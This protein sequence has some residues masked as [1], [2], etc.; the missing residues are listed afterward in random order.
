M[1]AK[2]GY[3][4]ITSDAEANVAFRNS[5]GNLQSGTVY[6]DPLGLKSLGSVKA[7]ESSNIVLNNHPALKSMVDK[8]NY[9][10][11]N[12]KALTTE[13]G[14]A[15][16]AGYALVPVYVDPRIIDRSIKRLP[17][18]TLMPRVA[19]NGMYAA[20]NYISSKGGAFTAA[21]DAS[22]SETNTAYDRSATAIKFLYSVGRTTGPSIAATPSYSLEGVA[23]GNEGIGPASYTE[24]TA[25][26]AN[27]LEIL[28]KTRELKELEENLL[29]NGNS[30]TSGVSGNPDGTEFN[31]IIAIQ[32]TTNKV[33]KNTSAI[34]L[35]DIDTAIQYAFDNGG[36]PTI[37]VCDSSTY[38]DLL[39]LLNNKIGYMQAQSVTEWGFTGIKLNTM[40]GP[41]TIVPSM[42][43][44]TSSGSKS[45]YF[46]D[47][48]VWE[49]RVLQ[50]ITFEPLAKV[51]DTNKFMLKCYETLICRAPQRNA[52]IGEIS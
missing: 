22:L 40:V 4:G 26:N 46:L 1:K 28:V 45:I 29:I 36:Q 25:P 42:Y 39:G 27:Q 35:S 47:L 31:G 50:D 23:G 9:K 51:N 38:T 5:F 19:N 52:W 37:A 41:I 10:N 48:S 49:L 16:T 34:T 13:S 12:L 14:G 44:S 6:Y 24:G 15:G 17:L 7:K 43:L 3:S 30:S 20:F 32:S 11:K 8:K 21:E 2:T 33:D 18:V